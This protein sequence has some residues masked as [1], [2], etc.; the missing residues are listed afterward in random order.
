[1]KCSYSL[2]AFLGQGDIMEVRLNMHVFKVRASNFS[3]DRG[4]CL[5]VAVSITK[6]LSIVVV[7][8]GNFY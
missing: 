6:G 5:I 3:V 8:W 4:V 1:M 2:L 7:S